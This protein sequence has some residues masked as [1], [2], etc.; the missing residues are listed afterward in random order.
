M[1]TFKERQER[2]NKRQYEKWLSCGFRGD[3]VIDKSGWCINGLS[4]Y[5]NDNVEEQILFDRPRYIARIS[6][7]QLPNGKWISGSSCT[8]P[9]QGWGHGLSVWDTQYDT[10]EEAVEKELD[11]IEKSLDEKDKKTFVLDAIR[12]CRTALRP[13]EIAL[14]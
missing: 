12:N 13:L 11:Y 8:F 7:M 1:D 6:F 4:F 5:K 10:K 9:L 2:E 3:M 14:F